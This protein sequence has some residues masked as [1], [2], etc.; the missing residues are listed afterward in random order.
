MAK[1]SNNKPTGRHTEFD[2]TWTDIRFLTE[3]P[4]EYFRAL[5]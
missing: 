5:S 4:L 2:G 1:P 3:M